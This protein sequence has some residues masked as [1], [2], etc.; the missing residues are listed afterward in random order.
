MVRAYLEDLAKFL[1]VFFILLALIHFIDFST[2]ASVVA[3]VESELLSTLGFT[4]LKFKSTVIVNSTPFLI[5][6]DC[7]GV[8]LI[9]L[10]FSLFVSTQTGSLKQFILFSILLFFFNITRLLLTLEVGSVYGLNAMEL[11]HVSL[12]LVDSAVV[13]IIWLGVAGF[14]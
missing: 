5:T 14:I 9:I 10:L 7:T 4:V 2:L 11:T 3:S 8:V 1:L 13:F 6:V 12:W